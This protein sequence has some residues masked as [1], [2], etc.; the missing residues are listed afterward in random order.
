MPPEE[1]NKQPPGTLTIRGK[2]SITIRVPDV[3]VMQPGENREDGSVYLGCFADP[4]DGR[5]KDWFCTADDLKDGAGRRLAP[6]FNTACKQVENLDAHGRNDWEIPPAAILDEQH[7]ARHT[8]AFRGTYDKSE[9]VPG[10]RYLSS[11]E[12]PNDG[13]EIWVRYID[14]GYGHYSP[15]AVPGSVRPVR[16]EPRP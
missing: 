8:G 7:K 13:R 3:L 15:K 5:L 11:L 10:A 1:Q 2:F 4:R 12:N 16:S 14:N 6:D 9:S